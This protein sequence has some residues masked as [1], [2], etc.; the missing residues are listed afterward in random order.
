[1]SVPPNAYTK[2]TPPGAPKVAPRR[3]AGLPQGR[4]PII[5]GASALL[6]GGYYLYSAGGDSKVARASAER[7]FPFSI[8][9]YNIRT[10][11]DEST[12]THR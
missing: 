12:H 7:K 4:L 5:L 10:R 8:N 1:M 6:L 9:Q 2:T 3:I 11:V